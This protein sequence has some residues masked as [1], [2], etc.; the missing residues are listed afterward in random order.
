MGARS[1]RG[2]SQSN[3]FELAHGERSRIRPV[4]DFASKAVSGACEM[5]GLRVQPDDNRSV[6]CRCLRREE[7]PGVQ[8]D[9]ESSPR[10]R[11]EEVPNGACMNVKSVPRRSCAAWHMACGPGGRRVPDRVHAEV[12]ILLRFC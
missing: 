8:P 7:V 2:H 5:L 1:E 3:S 12:K 4:S 11:R 6:L 9:G 10:S